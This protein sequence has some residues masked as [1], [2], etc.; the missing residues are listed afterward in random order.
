MFRI[1]RGVLLL[2]SNFLGVSRAIAEKGAGSGPGVMTMPIRGR[3][4]WAAL[5]LALALLPAAANAQNAYITNSGDNTVSVIDTA[6][7]NVVGTP[8]PVGSGPEGVAA[9]PDGAKVYIANS[10]D[11]TVSVIDTA[12][13]TVVAIT[14]VGG[15]P[16]PV[17]G[18]V[19]VAVTPDGTKAF[20]TLHIA[21]PVARPC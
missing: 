14:P 19:G 6:T 9:T 16:F 10:G 2:A 15:G 12:T 8:I 3:A 5:P 1:L 7:N 21:A 18:P 13:N 20:V 17:Q 4:R 11:N